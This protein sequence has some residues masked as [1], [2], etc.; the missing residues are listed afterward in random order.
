VDE[1]NHIIKEVRCFLS[2]CLFIISSLGQAVDGI[3]QNQPYHHNK[4]S[5]WNANIVEQVLKRLT[6]LNKPFKYIGAPHP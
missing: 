4:V 3:I 2:R 6:G 5:Q 1:V